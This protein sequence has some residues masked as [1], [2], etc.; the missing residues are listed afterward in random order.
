VLVKS[1][2]IDC[3][4]VIKTEISNVEQ[5][6][7]GSVSDQTERESVTNKDSYNYDTDMNVS[8]GDQSVVIE[9]FEVF[10]NT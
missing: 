4:S 7:D 6:L 5:E 2:Q 8:G 3:D 9:K 10:L 1:E